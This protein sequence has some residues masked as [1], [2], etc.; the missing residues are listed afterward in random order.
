MAK[1]IAERAGFTLVE[2]MIV[3]AI[4]GILAAIGIPSFVT[5]VRRAK[6]TE[7]K[8][9]LKHIFNHA[10]SYFSREIMG[11]G[12]VS[13]QLMWCT[14]GSTNNDVTPT[15]NRQVGRYTAD[16]WTALG[17]KAE[18]S[19][20]RYEIENQVNAA[21]LCGTPPGTARTYALRA[22][23]DLDAD[24]VTSLIELA[25]AT[26]ND[27]ELYHASQFYEDNATE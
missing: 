1:P 23:G 4:L 18:A 22:V 17:F 7:A 13:S 10:A 21:G 25:V 12:L 5:Y 3:V 27:N 6:T 14:V 9:N 2:L 20:Y 8:M 15:A 24:G 16:P 19:Y 11:S 26:T